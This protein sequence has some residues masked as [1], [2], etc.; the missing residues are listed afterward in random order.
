[1]ILVSL[2][3]TLVLSV[4]QVSC[5]RILT[6]FPHEGRSHLYVF[7]PV[8]HEL[9]G[10][11]HHITVITRHTLGFKSNN[12]V[13]VILEGKFKGVNDYSLDMFDKPGLVLA[14]GSA[15]VLTSMGIDSCHSIYTNPQVQNL[16]KSDEKFDLIIAEM[17]NNECYLGFADKFKAPVIGFSSTT[18][19]SWH[20]ARF[21]QPTNPSYIPNNHFRSGGKMGFFSRL[22]NFLGTSWYSLVHLF[23]VKYNEKVYGKYYGGQID[24]FDDLIKN[25]SLLL[26]NSHFSLH[27]PIPF[28]PGVVEIGGVHIGAPKKIPEV[29]LRA[30]PSSSMNVFISL[31]NIAYFFAPLF[32]F[33]ILAV[34]PHQGRSHQSV[35][36]PIVRDL[37]GRGHK[38]TVIVHYSYD[39]KNENYKEILLGDV[40]GTGHDFFDMETLEVPVIISQL[41][42][43]FLLTDLGLESCSTML[44]NAEVR[45]LVES[46]KRFDLILA[47]FFNSE[48]VLGFV[49]AFE[50]PLVGITTGILM[51]WHGDRLGNPDNPS[52]IASSHLGQQAE[53]GFWNRLYNLIGTQWYKIVYW[54][55]LTDCQKIVEEHFRRTFKPFQESMK[56]ISMLLVNSHF[57][58]TFPRPLVPGI[59][60][61]GG[62]H[63]EKAKALPGVSV[64]DKTQV[65]LLQ[66]VEDSLLMVVGFEINIASSIILIEIKCMKQGEL[67]Y[68]GWVA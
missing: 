60:E 68:K 64:S 55:K 49:G 30:I 57:S 23:Q 18:L 16:M 32:A 58:L 31:L 48:C 37:V 1:M 52:Y 8:I 40:N 24:S 10:R 39:V 44:S 66:D 12:L 2:W 35:F 62:V 21:G 63:I 3:A 50:A 13:E 34:F 56:D 41:I 33:D 59:I 28:V 46:D 14:F 54:W 27:Q 53:M 38:L 15:V 43:P 45:E 67:K 17:F 25:S 36:G 5:L 19:M 11:G 26:V 61:V 7:A 51:P 6:V 22:E 42:H 20:A 4:T 65:E 9:L 47:E 29:I